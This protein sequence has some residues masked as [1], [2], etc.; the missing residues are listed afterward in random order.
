MRPATAST[1]EAHSDPP[2]AGSSH[3]KTPGEKQ[4]V[5][6]VKDRLKAPGS[7]REPKQPAGKSQPVPSARAGKL[8]MWVTEAPSSGLPDDGC[9]AGNMVLIPCP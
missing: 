5:I 9:G 4:A 1:V 6:L 3:S 7:L 2:G 8:E